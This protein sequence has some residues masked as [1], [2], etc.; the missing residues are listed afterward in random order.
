MGVIT[1]KMIS[2]TRTTSTRG[3]TLMSPLGPGFD[4]PACIA[5]LR[6]G[7]EIE[8]LGLDGVDVGLQVVDA[9]VEVVEDPDGGDGDEESERGRDERFGDSSRDRAETAG[10]G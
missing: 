3:V 7:K 8:D 5:L 6:S 4:L 2:S 10:A 1:M 9:A